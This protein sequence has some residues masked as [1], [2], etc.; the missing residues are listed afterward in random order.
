MDP[1]TN[2]QRVGGV[3]RGAL[4]VSVFVTFLVAAWIQS[5]LACSIVHNDSLNLWLGS[6]WL[7]FVSTYA[8]TIHFVGLVPLMVVGGVLSFAFI[9]IIEVLTSDP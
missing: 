4:S 2:V 9:A 5:E 1:E 7:R 8:E 3:T 6:G